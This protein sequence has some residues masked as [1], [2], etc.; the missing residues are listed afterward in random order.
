M[1]VN[2]RPADVP[3]LWTHFWRLQ[4][5]HIEQLR[6]DSFNFRKERVVCLISHTR[7]LLVFLLSHHEPYSVHLFSHSWP[8]PLPTVP[9]V[10]PILC[11]LLHPRTVLLC[12][13]IALVFLL[14]LTLTC[15][16]MNEVAASRCTFPLGAVFGQPGSQR[17]LMPQFLPLPHQTI[18]VSVLALIGPVSVPVLTLTGFASCSDLTLTSLGLGQV[19]VHARRTKLQIFEMG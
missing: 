18:H 8:D 4:R 14:E 16:S 7:A 17:R 15:Q 12:L 13:T 9:L 11:L 10:D 6:H 3:P 5:A 19:S 1:S 2:W